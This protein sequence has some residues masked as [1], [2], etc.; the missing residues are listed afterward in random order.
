VFVTSAERCGV[1]LRSARAVLDI[2]LSACWDRVAFLYC[3]G[4][5][6]LEVVEK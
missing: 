5:G 2:G 3:A 4:C 6:S 1:V